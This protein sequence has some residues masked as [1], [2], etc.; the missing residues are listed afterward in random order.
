ML[1]RWRPGLRAG[2]PGD[3]LQLFKM[4]LPIQEFDAGHVQAA[5]SLA[6][7]LMVW[8]VTASP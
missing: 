8:T 7:W 5:A 2:I 3:D 1:S 6:S 4:S